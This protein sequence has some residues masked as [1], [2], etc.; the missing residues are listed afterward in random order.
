MTIQELQSQV[1]HW[2]KTTGNGYFDPL[3]NMAILSEEVGE[4]ARVIARTDGMQIAKEGE[5]LNFN[6]EL[7]DILWVIVCLANQKD[8]DLTKE[9]HDSFVKKTKRDVNRFIDVDK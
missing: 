6:E 5:N 7:A 3:T 2:I 9:L 8:V 4:L 1:D